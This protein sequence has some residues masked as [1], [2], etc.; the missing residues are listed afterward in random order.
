MI[1]NNLGTILGQHLNLRASVCFIVFCF[2]THPHMWKFPFSWKNV[3]IIMKKQLP[4]HSITEKRDLRRDCLDVRTSFVSL[5]ALPP[6]SLLE[7][8]YRVVDLGNEP[9][10]PVTL[11]WSCDNRIHMVLAVFHSKVGFK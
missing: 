7:Q 8:V 9:T 11:R 5:P 3:Y 1:F 2:K 6:S 10:A 4:D